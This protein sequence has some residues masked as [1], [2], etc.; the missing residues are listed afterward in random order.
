MATVRILRSNPAVS[1]DDLAA[2]LM[3]A[4]DLDA[5][6]AFALVRGVANAPTQ[7]GAEQTGIEMLRRVA[8]VL[9][10]NG[11]EIVYDA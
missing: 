4:T 9:E 6:E 2:A 7:I 8:A 5:D 1:D 11:F 10:N 3:D